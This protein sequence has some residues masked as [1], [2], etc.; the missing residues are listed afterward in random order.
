MTTKNDKILTSAQNYISSAN[1]EF[2]ELHEPRV[3]IR[4]RDPSIL[5]SS[6]TSSQRKQNYVMAKMKREEIEKQNEAAI[7]LVKQKE[8]MQLKKT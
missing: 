1:D 2:N 8:P 5:A 7:H 4:S 3:L 6:K